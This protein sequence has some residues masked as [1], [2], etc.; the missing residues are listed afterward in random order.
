[1]TPARYLAQPLRARPDAARDVERGDARRRLS[2]I[3]DAGRRPIEPVGQFEPRRT[4]ENSPAPAWLTPTAEVEWLEPRPL[5]LRETLRRW[6]RLRRD[7]HAGRPL[8]GAERLIVAGVVTVRAL[9]WLLSFAIVAVGIVA[10]AS[11]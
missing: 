8:V 11:S 1:M 7:L 2:L 6:R 10:L 5:T 9:L 4:F 3:R